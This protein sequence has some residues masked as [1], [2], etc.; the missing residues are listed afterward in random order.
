MSIEKVK[1]ID[2]E[3]KKHQQKSRQV[4]KRL[5]EKRIKELA[6]SAEELESK[7][8]QLQNR[9]DNLNRQIEG[10]K[11]ENNKLRNRLTGLISFQGV[12]L[13]NCSNEDFE[14]VKNQVSE[15]VNLWNQNQ[16]N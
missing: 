8:K 9:I 16:Q 5:R 2:A 1:K 12:D 4:M 13:V 6:G 10:V 3:I 14:N 15:M 7:N 11:N